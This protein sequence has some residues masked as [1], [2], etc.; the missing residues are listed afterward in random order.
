LRLDTPPVSG[1]NPLCG[2]ATKNA[3]SPD[4]KIEGAVGIGQIPQGFGIQAELK[5]SLPGLDKEAAQK[6]VEAAHRVPVL[7]RHCG[8][9]DVTLIV[10]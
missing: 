8:N 2:R 6:L 10:V 4:A 7:E 5:I 3:I 1:R 9:I